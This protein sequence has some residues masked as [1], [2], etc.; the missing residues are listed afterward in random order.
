MSDETPFGSSGSITDGPRDPEHDRSAHYALER[1]FVSSLTRRIPS[2]TGRERTV[3][4][5]IGLQPLGTVPESSADDV[6]EAFRRA[7][8]A[9]VGWAATPVSVRAKALMR[10]HDI[11]LDRQEE[12]IDL[13]VW[14]SGKA[15]KDAFLEVAHLALTARYYARTAHQHLDSR[16]VAGMFPVFTRV[17]VHRVPKGVVGIIAPWNYPLTMALCDG[18]PALLAGNAVVSKPDSQTTL[19]ALLA[20]Q[21]LDQAGFPR[22]TW[23]VVSGPP[24]EV[25]GAVVQQAD[26]VCFTG[27]SATGRLIAAQCAERLVGCSLE[28]GGKNPMLVLRDA[29]IDRAAEGAVRAAFPNAGQLCVSIE[30]MYVANEIHDRFLDQFVARTRALTL[31]AS[32]DWS[33][34]MGSLISQAQ[35]D[36]VS[37]HVADAVAKG[38]V[39]RAG[40]RARPDLGPFVYEPT[41]L[42]GVTPEM[43]CYAEET[44]GP[45]VAIHRF[46]DEGEAVRLANGGEYG[47]NA[48]VWTRDGAR[49]RAIAKRLVAGTVNVNEGYGAAFGSVGAP[50]GGMRQSGLGRRQGAEGILR[51]TEAQSV[52]TQRVIPIRPMFSMSEEKHAAV[53]TRAVR[54]L[55]KLGRV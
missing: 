40:G 32:H 35:L 7:R 38:A 42:E 14:E 28:L 29:D 9:Q 49:G 46:H 5:P 43:D 1:S 51:Y 33:V 20:A 26:Y 8:V 41:I 4:S 50:M 55:N 54:L 31:G 22:D 53:M 34:D 17:D 52:G 24:A 30:R 13:V 48:S 23:Q 6:A 11:L 39:V 18:L 36:K 27:S 44:F 2:T 3:V 45:V 47:L 37:A 19:T 15:R 25:G 16:R 12:L 10:L 21:L